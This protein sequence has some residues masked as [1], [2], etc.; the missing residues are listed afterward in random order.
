MQNWK[1]HINVTVP[2][3]SKQHEPHQKTEVNL[4]ALE[5]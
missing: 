5:G 4:G 1:N 3:K 2:K